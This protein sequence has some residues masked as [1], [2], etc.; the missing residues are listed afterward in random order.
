MT[1][2][3]LPPVIQPNWLVCSSCNAPIVTAA[4]LISEE[5]DVLKNAVY[6]Y[7][8]DM[9]EHDVAVYSATNTADHRFDV[10]R[11]ILSET[12]S[13]PPTSR[14]LPDEREGL[15]L[16]LRHFHVIS[17]SDQEEH[18]VDP[19]RISQDLAR[20][21]EGSQYTSEEDDEES[22]SESEESGETPSKRPRMSSE[23]ICG[24]VET[25]FDEPTNEYSW[26]PSYSWTAASCAVC[27]E[28][29]G[30]V[31]WKQDETEKWEIKFLSLVVTRLREKFIPDNSSPT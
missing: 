6:A 29:L 17:L 3:S 14:T 15:R 12:V 2:S 21:L 24:R 18:V 30:W 27:H 28:H 11:A 20:L 19:A 4:E 26:F 9:L 31:F 8:L 10:V 25:Q 23:T 5:V 1:D 16:F 22:G 13:V 7:R